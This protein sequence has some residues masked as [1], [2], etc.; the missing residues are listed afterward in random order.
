V[1]YACDFDRTSL[2]WTQK[3][4]SSATEDNKGSLYN[5]YIIRLEQVIQVI[6]YKLHS[7]EGALDSTEETGDAAE[8][9]ELGL[10]WVR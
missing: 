3:K 10:V 8:V 5:Y 1:I 6:K 9:P 7:W 2:N 4:H